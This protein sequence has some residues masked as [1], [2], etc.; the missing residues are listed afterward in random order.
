M[1]E[2]AK[3]NFMLVNVQIGNSDDKLTQREWAA[4]VSDVDGIM[5]YFE[6]ARHFFGGSTTYARWQNV[7]WVCY[8]HEDH[9]EVLKQSLRECRE[10]HRQDSV[11]VLVGEELFV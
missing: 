4:Y 11:C 9:I 10:K 6:H 7:C 3:G 2:D 1:V 8:V 5:Q